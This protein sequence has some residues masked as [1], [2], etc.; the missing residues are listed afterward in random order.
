MWIMNMIEFFFNNIHVHLYVKHCI[1]I[2]SRH[3]PVVPT[4]L[5]GW[6]KVDNA[7]FNFI[8]DITW[9]YPEKTTDLPQ[10]TD[11]LYYIMLYQ[12]HLS[13]VGCELTTLVVIGTDCTSSCKSTTICSRPMTATPP[14]YIEITVYKCIPCS[15]FLVDL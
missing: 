15:V 4:N 5:A 1:S 3:C 7:T 13:W 9:R 6:F 14:K 8:S 11:K 2:E 10:V 12:V